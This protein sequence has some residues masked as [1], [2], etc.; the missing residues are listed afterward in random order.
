M[1]IL[2]PL[3]GE[4]VEPTERE[5]AFYEQGFKEAD[6]TRAERTRGPLPGITVL[7][8]GEHLAVRQWLNETLAGGSNSYRYDATV[9]KVLLLGVI[10]EQRILELIQEKR[11]TKGGATKYDKFFV[12]ATET[13]TD[14]TAEEQA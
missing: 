13:D 14:E 8:T 2:I 5:M 11:S 10:N 9:D 4:Y 3:N 7:T 1:T 12:T 6:V